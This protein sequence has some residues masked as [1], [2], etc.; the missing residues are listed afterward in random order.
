MVEKGTLIKN[1]KAK[2]LHDREKIENLNI[3]PED[4]FIC[5]IKSGK[6]W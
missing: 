4:I 2:K 5:E 3:T 1:I 6:S